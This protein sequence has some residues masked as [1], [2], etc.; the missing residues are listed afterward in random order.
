MEPNELMLAAVAALGA[1][2]SAAFGFILN[3]IRARL[4]R[5]ESTLADHERRISF[6]EGVRE[7]AR[8]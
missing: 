7:T 5:H 3:G 6:N 1:V 8:D 2:V 4:D